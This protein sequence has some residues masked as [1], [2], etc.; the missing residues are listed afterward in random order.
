MVMWLLGRM[1]DGSDGIA[2]CGSDGIAL[3][4]ID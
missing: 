2:V 1:F 4:W 3:S